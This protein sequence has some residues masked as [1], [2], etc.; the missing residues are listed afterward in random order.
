LSDLLH[1]T[2]NWF[3]FTR[4]SYRV[5]YPD[6]ISQNERKFMK[7]NRIGSFGISI[8]MLTIIVHSQVKAQIRTRA[9]VSPEVH[10]DQTAIFRIMTKIETCD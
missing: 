9:I 5:F 10:P 8:I 6:K 1:F 4:E 3:R 7:N 2:K